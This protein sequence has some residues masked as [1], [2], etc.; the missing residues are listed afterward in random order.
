L[1]QVQKRLR[2]AEVKTDAE[3]EGHGDKPLAV[4]SP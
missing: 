4:F 2:D 1:R 3:R